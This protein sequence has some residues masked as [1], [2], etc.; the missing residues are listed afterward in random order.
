MVAWHLCCLSVWLLLSYLFDLT[1]L[2]LSQHSLST[3]SC[4]YP[5][6]ITKDIHI[7]FI[8]LSV[9]YFLTYLVPISVCAYVWLWMC[10]KRGKVREQNGEFDVMQIYCIFRFTCSQNLFYFSPFLEISSV[11]LFFT[12]QTVR[13]RSK[14]LVNYTCPQIHDISQNRKM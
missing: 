3:F 9:Q 4:A 7:L 5:R 8:C 14:A 11:F 10:V 2:Y 13:K 1:I 12:F 6:G